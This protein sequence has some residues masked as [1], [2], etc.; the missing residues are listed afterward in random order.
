[1]SVGFLRTSDLLYVSYISFLPLLLLI[2]V[3]KSVPSGINCND[4]RS[5]WKNYILDVP[6]P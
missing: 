6:E 2:H 1:M 5:G 3:Q 4:I